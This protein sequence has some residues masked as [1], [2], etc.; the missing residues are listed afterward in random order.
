MPTGGYGTLVQYTAILKRTK[1]K[2]DPQACCHIIVA[3]YNT[4]NLP[5]ADIAQ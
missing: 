5:H 4:G 2:L 3:V 1:R